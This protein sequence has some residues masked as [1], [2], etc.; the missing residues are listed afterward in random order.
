MKKVLL[1]VVLALLLTSTVQAQPTTLPMLDFD[2]DGEITINDA[3][4]IP[5]HFGELDYVALWAYDLDRDGAITQ[6][7]GL[8]VVSQIGRTDLPAPVWCA[9]ALTQ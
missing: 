8:I 4:S 3:L 6:W 2:C 7:D 5:P 1:V 9:G